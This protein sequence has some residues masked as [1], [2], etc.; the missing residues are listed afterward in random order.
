MQ[1]TVERI[2]TTTPEAAVVAAPGLTERQIMNRLKKH[3]ELKA[4]IKALTAEKDA[5]EAEIMGAAEAVAIDCEK[6]MLDAGKEPYKTFDGK[7]FKADHPDM[8]AAYQK[9][10]ARSKFRYKFY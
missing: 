4:Q 7:A 9:Q 6:F 3:A 5:I 1:T 8:Y 2:A 10:S